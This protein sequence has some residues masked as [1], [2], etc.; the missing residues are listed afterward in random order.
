MPDECERA[1][2]LGAS[3]AS[4]GTPEAPTMV[5]GT[6]GGNYG[7]HRPGLATGP[8]VGAA[9][10]SQQAGP[11]YPDAQ[12]ADPNWLAFRPQRFRSFDLATGTFLGY[13]GQRQVCQC[14]E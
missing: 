11:T 13:D 8:I 6:T 1:I 10:A 3:M 12:A 2:E 4:S 9:V 7:E 14:P 5:D